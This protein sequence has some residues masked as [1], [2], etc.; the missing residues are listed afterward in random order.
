MAMLIGLLAALAAA[1]VPLTIG[2]EWGSERRMAQVMGVAHPHRRFDL[3]RLARESGTG[4]QPHQII[5]G[6]LAWSVGGFLLGLP[7][8]VFVALLFGLAG[9]LIYWGSLT[10]KREDRRSKQAVQIARAMGII[11]TVLSQGRPLHDALEQ[12]AQASPLE[13]REVLEDLVRRMRQVSA[14][15]M[16]RAVREW[17]EAWDNPA[18]DMLAAALLAAL[19]SR[20]EVAPLVG[21]LQENIMDVTDTLRRTHA[22]A[23]GIIWQSRFLAFWPIIVLAIISLATPSWAVAYRHNPLLILPALIGSAL[24]WA[25]S[26]RQIR[27]GLSVDAAV[28]IGAHGEGEIQL[29]RLGKVL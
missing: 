7:Q 29:D 20:I 14:N 21:S 23:Q 27:N 13:G 9:G 12:A 16:A 1:A 4:L 25:L 19:E 28:G 6:L 8:G 24:T 11:E 5:M 18:T 17:D 10:D 26:M 22:E 3:A 2:R 15:E